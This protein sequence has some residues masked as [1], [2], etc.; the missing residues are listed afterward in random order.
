MHLLAKP[1]SLKE[2]AP[3]QYIATFFQR[4][5]FCTL[6]PHNLIYSFYKMK[7]SNWLVISIVLMVVSSCAPKAWSVLSSSSTK[8]AIDSTTNVTADKGFEAYIQP[9][10]QKIDVQMNE[11]IGVSAV[12]MKASLPESLLSNLNADA[13][14]SVATRELGQ[15]V[16][17]AIVN[18]GGL[19]TVIPEGNITVRK[20]F[21]LMPFENELV[22][23]WLRGDKL[24]A[25][26]QQFASVGGQGVSGLR[27]VIANGAAQN[28]SINGKTLDANELYLIATNDY[29]AGGNDKMAQLTACEKR[30]N[31]GLKIRDVLL[32]FIKNETKKGN[33]IDAK[34]DGRISI[35]N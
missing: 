16:D 9:I 28:I 22:I 26:I 1:L 13:Y 35:A 4:I 18:M 14:R 11:V 19:R 8:I 7:L 32:D 12:T 10:K 21:E 24:L 5:I 23:L 34:L 25:L 27:F 2:E 3:G 30:V 29:L 17:I 20:V 33:K 6:A 31:T 15:T